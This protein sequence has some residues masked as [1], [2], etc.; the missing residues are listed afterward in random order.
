M[1]R[2]FQPVSAVILGRSDP[3]KPSGRTGRLLYE[4]AELETF[5]VGCCAPT[6]SR[7]ICPL[8]VTDSGLDIRAPLGLC[9]LQGFHASGSSMTIR[10]DR[11]F[12]HAHSIVRMLV[13]KLSGSW[14]L[15]QFRTMCSLVAGW[16]APSRQIRKLAWHGFAAGVS[17]L[18][19]FS[20][21]RLAGAAAVAAPAAAAV[22]V[23]VVVAVAAA[24]AVAVAVAHTRVRSRDGFA[25]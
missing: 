14:P 12:W 23:T 25:E 5:L 7:P 6:S 21:C 18:L 2:R 15:A 10:C 24:V 9:N 16:L 19:H 3:D 4:G 20:P 1:G 22:V 17:A 13:A 11:S 8:L